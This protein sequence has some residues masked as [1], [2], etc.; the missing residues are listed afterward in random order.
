MYPWKILTTS[1]RNLTSSFE[2]PRPFVPKLHQILDVLVFFFIWNTST[3]PMSLHLA[4]V[5]SVV[6]NVDDL[7]IVEALCFQSP[8]PSVVIPIFLST[9]RRST[10]LL[11]L[12]PIMRPILSM[13]S[14]LWW[15]NQER[16]L[17]PC[18]KRKVS[19]VLDSSSKIVYDNSNISWDS[20]EIDRWM[21][22]STNERN[23][24]SFDW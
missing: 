7:A 6:V 19:F 12:H 13:F 9:P 8:T 2:L 16:I 22:Y 21:L 5:V 3:T 17:S 18:Q 23:L 14:L 10:I 1:Q 15:H 20:T 4:V 11:S 24:N